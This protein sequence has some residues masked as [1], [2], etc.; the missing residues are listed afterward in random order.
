MN[1][2]GL[3]LRRREGLPAPLLWG[4]RDALPP[5]K[6]W[7]GKERDHLLP[8]QRLLLYTGKRLPFSLPVGGAQPKGRR[9]AKVSKADGQDWMVG[10]LELLWL[11]DR[12]SGQPESEERWWPRAERGCSGAWRKEREPHPPARGWNMRPCSHQAWGGRSPPSAVSGS[13][14]RALLI[15]LGSKERRLAAQPV[16]SDQEARGLFRSLAPR[17]FSSLGS[18][19]LI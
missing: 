15:S 11:F 4:K 7:Q 1:W 18:I 14:C 5:G 10:P 19:K 9:Q 13:R 8:R 6:G 17:T 3:C 12:D 2:P 16:T